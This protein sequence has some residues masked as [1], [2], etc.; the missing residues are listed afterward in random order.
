MPTTKIPL[1]DLVAQ[2]HSIKPE[3]DAAIQRVLESGHF[4]LGGEVSSLESE[5]VAYLG[6]GHGIGVASG[7]DALI[8]YPEMTSEQVEMVAKTIRKFAL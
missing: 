8:L 7:T 4:I 3:I 1:L 5:V 2:Y 6:V